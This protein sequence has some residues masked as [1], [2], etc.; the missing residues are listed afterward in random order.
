[1][2]KKS[3]YNKNQHIMKKNICIT[4]MLF[5]VLSGY[6]QPAKDI[7]IDEKTLGATTLTWTENS[8]E[9]NN[10]IITEFLDRRIAG[11]EAQRHTYWNRDYAGVESYEKSVEKNRERFRFITGVRDERL[12]FEAPERCET[13]ESS[14]LFAETETHKIHA[15]RWTVFEDLKG[16]GLLLEPKSKGK[17]QRA[18]IH[19]PHAGVTPEQLLGLEPTTANAFFVPPKAGERM[20]IISTVNRNVERRKLVSLTNREY[21]Y[22][23]AYQLGRH[24]IGYE[25]QEVLALTDWLKKDKDAH[26]RLEGQGDGGLIALYAAAADRRIDETLVVDYFDNRDRI[27]EEPIDRNVFGLLQQ[28][29]DAEIASLIAPRKLVIGNF[30]APELTLSSKG[31]GAPG[32]LRKPDAKVVKAEIERAKKMVE[33]LNIPNWIEYREMPAKNNS[34][35]ATLTGK[36]PNTGERVRRLVRGMDKHTQM[37]LDSSVLTRRT[38]WNRLDESSPEKIAATIEWYRDY[39]AKNIIGVFDDAFLPPN[40]KIRLHSEDKNY[41]AYETELDVFDGLT[42]YGLLLIPRGMKEGE[43]RPVVVCQHGLERGATMHIRGGELNGETVFASELC[44]LGYIVFTPQGIFSLE[45]KY[46][47]N[48]RQLNPLGKN[49][50]SVMTA[51]HQQICN[52]LGALPFV[53]SE[54]IALYGVSYGGTTVMS[55]VPLIPA[56]CLSICSANFNYWNYKLANTLIDSNWSS[57]YV[58]LPYYEMFEFDMANTFD[59]SDMARLIAPRP[60]MVERG[61][62]DGVAWDEYVGFEF[63]KVRYFYDHCLKIPERAEILWMDGGHTTY[64]EQSHLFIDKFLKKRKTD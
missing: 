36:I 53:D 17:P 55:I 47:F 43:K 40:P 7:V 16:E 37:L 21:I 18:V 64:I 10:R 1:M 26:V 34:I 11:S 59:H 46:R 33:P 41:T 50:F 32:R 56:Y 45:D 44:D 9:R 27:C 24:I 12:S 39:F 6:A 63:G 58:F 51:Q 52:W 13:L 22:R 60:F 3:I 4:V 23:T 29:G 57:G 35:S 15:I 62:L 8:I 61:H 42:A 2:M 49:L 25:V 54:R 30:D 20:I 28:F 48:Q 31:G 38:F 19:I 5:T 14:A